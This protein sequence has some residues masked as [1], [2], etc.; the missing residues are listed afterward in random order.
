MSHVKRKYLTL[1]GLKEIHSF[2]H[3]FIHS[4]PLFYVDVFL[5]QNLSHAVHTMKPQDILSCTNCSQTM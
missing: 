5:V 4:K 1:K 2:I 3:S